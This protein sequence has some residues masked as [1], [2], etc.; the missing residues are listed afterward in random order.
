METVMIA[1][2]AD[3]RK[4]VKEAVKESIES[5]KPKEVLVT[6]VAET[7]MSRKEIAARLQISLVTL[8]EW[9]KQG[10]PSHKQQ[11]RVYFLYSEVMEYIAKKRPT[12]K[13]LWDS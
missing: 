3:I 1:S 8:T 13:Y 5:A 7:F 4:W 11:R 10:L 12:K 2:E 6:N 9:V